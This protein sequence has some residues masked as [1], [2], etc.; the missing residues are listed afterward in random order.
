M[1]ERPLAGHFRLTV[2]PD[3]ADLEIRLRAALSASGLDFQL[4]R[5]LEPNVPVPV[6]AQVEGGGQDYPAALTAHPGTL[7]LV[8]GEYD[9]L[10]ALRRALQREGYRILAATSGEQAL[11]LMAANK[12]DVILAAQRMTPMSGV[13]LLRRVRTLRPQAVRMVLSGP[14][15]FQSMADAI[16]EGAIYRFLA[17]PWKDEQLV[18]QIREAFAHKAMLDQNRRLQKELSAANAAMSS[19][20]AIL[21]TLLSEQQARGDRGEA[22]LAVAR[23]VLQFLPLPIIGIDVEDQIVM[24][25]AA[26]EELVGAMPLLGLDAYEALPG[27]LMDACD[28]NRQDEIILLAN[29]R[30][31]IAAHEMGLRSQSRG[32]LLVLTPVPELAPAPSG[33]T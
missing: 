26:T 8:D 2:T 27:V 24:V 1:L 6:A 31:T 28:A 18:G 29:R 14:S 23:E 25:N 33:A 7:L 13:E 9:V 15:E 11:A 21:H 4:V 16:N 3:S 10:T 19:A 20:N 22:T 30:F 5:Q 17:K 32:R 12:V